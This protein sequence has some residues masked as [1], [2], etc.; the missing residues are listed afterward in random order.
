MGHQRYQPTSNR[1]RSRSIATDDP[2]R[3]NVVRFVARGVCPAGHGSPFGVPPPM[4]TA[5]GS[6]PR[7]TEGQSMPA[8]RGILLIVELSTRRKPGWFPLGKSSTASVTIHRGRAVWY[9]VHMIEGCRCVA[10]GRAMFG[11]RSCVR[12]YA[13]GS[14]T[15]PRRHTSTG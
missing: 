10:G 6:P 15:T 4:P 8:A 11:P 12:H 13:T 14:G 7:F 3:W 5:L 2:T 9:H 1:E